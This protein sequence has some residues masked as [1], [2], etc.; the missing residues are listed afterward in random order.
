MN[1]YTI[2]FPF[3]GE[4]QFVYL[5]ANQIANA[6]FESTDDILDF[7]YNNKEQEFAQRIDVKG[8]KFDVTFNNN[9]IRC[10]NVYNVDEDGESGY[11]AEEAIPWLLLK[12]ENFEKEVIYNLNDNV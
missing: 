4:Y 8:K 2:T 1:K 12:I 7:L 9:N 6:V 5:T 3:Q 10:F 11:I